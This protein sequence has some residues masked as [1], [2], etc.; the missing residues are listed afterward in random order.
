MKVVAAEIES[1][2]SVAADRLVFTSGLYCLVSSGDNHYGRW[3]G[4]AASTVKCGRANGL[5]T[6]DK[7]K[8]YRQWYEYTKNHYTRR[9][10]IG[11][12]IMKIV[13]AEIHEKPLHP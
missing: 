4:T 1:R 9:L 6:S 8:A 2:G 7:E 3:D 10:T 5:C 11:E 13:A 12:K